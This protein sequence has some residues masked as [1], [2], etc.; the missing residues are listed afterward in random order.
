ML[1]TQEM[2]LEQLTSVSAIKAHNAQVNVANFKRI[3]YNGGNQT[4][5]G[6]GYNNQRGRGRTGYGRGNGNGRRVNRPICQ[7]CGRT[8][9]TAPKCYHRFDIS[10]NGNADGD[11]GTQ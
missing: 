10:F 3:G 5:H 11:T 8:G 2:R 4:H 7:L 6:R 1:Q 9:H